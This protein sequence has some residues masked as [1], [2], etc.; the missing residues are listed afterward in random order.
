MAC[1][2]AAFSVAPS[3]R[4]STCFEAAGVDADRRH[5]QVIADMEPVDLEHHEI[6]IVEHARQPGLQLALSR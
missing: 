5:H 1:T 3:A 2:V 6:E 4:P